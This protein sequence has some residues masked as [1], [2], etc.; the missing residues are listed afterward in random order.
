M[1]MD[2]GMSAV[3]CLCLVASSGLLAYTLVSSTKKAM[4]T[5]RACIGKVP[6]D[7]VRDLRTTFPDKVVRVGTAKDVSDNV[8]TVVVESKRVRCVYVGTERIE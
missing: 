2:M 1:E 4:A 7:A 8:I 3:A 6:E 5:V